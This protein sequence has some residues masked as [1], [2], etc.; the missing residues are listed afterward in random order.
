MH[1]LT[2]YFVSYSSSLQFLS[3]LLILV[4]TSGHAIIFTVLECAYT[5]LDEQSNHDSHTAVSHVSYHIT[6]LKDMPTGAQCYVTV[7]QML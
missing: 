5:I 7:A 4:K 2:I 6:Y 3:F 1:K